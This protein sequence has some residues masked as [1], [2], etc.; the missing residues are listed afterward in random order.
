MINFRCGGCA[1]RVEA[2]ASQAGTAVTCPRCQHVNVC[3]AASEAPAIRPPAP[4]RSGG[5]PESR[6]IV[7]GGSIWIFGAVVAI[8]ALAGIAWS[9]SGLFSPSAPARPPASPVEALQQELLRKNLDRPGDPLLAAQY[10]S[11]NAKHFSGALPAMPVLWEPELARVGELAGRKYNLEG[12]FGHVGRRMAILLNPDLQR[13]R[14]ALTRAL[15]HE[16]VHAYLHVT[17]DRSTQHGPAF[18]AVLQRLSDERAFEGVVATDDDRARL[19]AWIEAEDARLQRERQE[20]QQLDREIQRERAEVEA[21][22]ADLNNRINAANARGAGWP[23]RAE[24]AA[25]EAR[26]DAYNTRALDANTR[27]ERNRAD[28]EAFRRQVER[29]NLML[30]YPDGVDEAAAINPGGR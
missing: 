19:R 20:L 22:M 11:I 16:M 18:Q 7:S 29:Y 25:V 15:C 21:A 2:E 4:R 8:V 26:R 12:M 3:P 9:A 14:A 23:T 10:Q 24:T 5:V 27:L 28:H 6:V 17:G 1:G 13:D 30:V